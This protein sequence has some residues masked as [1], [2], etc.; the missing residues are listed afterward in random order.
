MESIERTLEEIN[1][2]EQ[3]V[4]NIDKNCKKINCAAVYDSILAIFKLLYDVFRCCRNK[5]D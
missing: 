5:N 1:V 4:E 3:D 2:I